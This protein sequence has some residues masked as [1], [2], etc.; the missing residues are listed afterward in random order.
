M[1]ETIGKLRE[2]IVMICLT[3]MI[4]GIASGQQMPTAE[5]G[6]IS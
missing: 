2:V 1:K 3:L 4:N 5:K 6:A